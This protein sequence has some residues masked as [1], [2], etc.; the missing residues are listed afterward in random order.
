MSWK[1]WTAVGVVIG[2]GILFQIP[3]HDDAQMDPEAMGHGDMPGEMAVAT[4]P[5]RTVALE[6]TGMT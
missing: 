6:V 5:Y 3:G 2:A 1:E 4:G